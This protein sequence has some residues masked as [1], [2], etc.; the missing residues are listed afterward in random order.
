MGIIYTIAEY[1]S[2]F[3]ID[4]KGQRQEN[5]TGQPPQHLAVA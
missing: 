3:G 4:Q 5:K 1:L 2:L